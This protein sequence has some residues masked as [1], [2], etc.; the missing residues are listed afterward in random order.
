MLKQVL[1]RLLNTNWTEDVNNADILTSETV[2]DITI[3]YKY[4]LGYLWI[5]IPE[6]KNNH[7][8]IN[9]NKW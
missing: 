2:D 5:T 9:K 6:N 1:G 7:T 4:Y 3:L 8:A